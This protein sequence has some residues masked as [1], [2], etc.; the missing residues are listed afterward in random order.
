MPSRIYVEHAQLEMA[1]ALQEEANLGTRP[2][3]AVV[4]RC[5]NSRLRNSEF[6]VLE[7]NVHLAAPL[8]LVVVENLF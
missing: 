7:R 1:C 6:I 8:F 4:H 5:A 3:F 2:D